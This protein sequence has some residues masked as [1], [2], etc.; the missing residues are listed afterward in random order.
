M[1]AYKLEGQVPCK[2]YLRA[3]AVILSTMAPHIAEELLEMIGEKS[4]ENQTW[5]TY[6]E[7]LIVE[8]AI[9]VAVQVNGKLRATLAIGSET[10][11]EI[12]A[13]AKTLENVAKNIE[14]KEIVKEI[15]VPN[16]IVNIVVK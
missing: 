7:S 13:K 10:K 15:Y 4:I 6:D 12:L 1:L 9:E 5:P 8:D 3:F 14:G 2:E 16:K 11:E